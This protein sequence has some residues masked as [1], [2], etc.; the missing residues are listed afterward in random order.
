MG[1]SGFSYKIGVFHTLCKGF[2]PAMNFSRHKSRFCQHFWQHLSR[3]VFHT[4][5]NIPIALCG[6]IGMQESFCS[7]RFK[8]SMVKDEGASAGLRMS[9][10]M[11]T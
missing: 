7:R 10:R 1:G 9:G 6:L 3:G 2:S 5:G 11:A 4:K 8:D